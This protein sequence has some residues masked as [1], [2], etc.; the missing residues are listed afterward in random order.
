[1]HV[2]VSRSRISGTLPIYQYRAL[3]P[4]SEVAAARRGHCMVIGAVLGNGRVP[5][6]RIADVIAPDAWFERNLAIPCG[7]AARLTLVAKRIEALIIRTVYPE[8][9]ANLPP[10]I[11]AL[12]H[13]PGKASYRIVTGDLNA[14]FDRFAS[15]IDTMMAA[16]LGLFQGCERHVA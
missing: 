14:A 10:V 6:T 3:V 1:M 15:T 8:M 16:D 9:T 2:I 5:S 11:F 4:L 13:D 7:L 12:D